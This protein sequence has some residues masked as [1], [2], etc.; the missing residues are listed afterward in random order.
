MLLGSYT[1]WMDVNIRVEKSI[2]NANNKVKSNLFGNQLSGGKWNTG[3]TFII[4]CRY[5]QYFW[6]WHSF[7]EKGPYTALCHWV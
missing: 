3:Y 4:H 2:G 1:N 6:F 7:Q 5:I